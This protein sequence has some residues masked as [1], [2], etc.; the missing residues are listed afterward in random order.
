M[1]AAVAVIMLTFFFSVQVTN[2]VGNSVLDTIDED[3]V[4]FDPEISKDL[5][6]G[7]AVPVVLVLRASADTFKKYREKTNDNARQDALDDAKDEIIA[8]LDGDFAENERLDTAFLMYGILNPEGKIKVKVRDDILAV[9]KRME[10]DLEFGEKNEADQTDIDILFQGV[11]RKT[12]GTVCLLS[13]GVD[14]YEDIEK[15]IVD[16][17]CYCA[18]N[19]CDD[20]SASD[21]ESASDNHPLKLGTSQASLLVNQKTGILRNA[22]VINVKVCDGEYCD[23][24][25]IVKGLDYCNRQNADLVLVTTQDAE[26]YVQSTCP[27]IMGPVFDA[28]L[29]K[30]IPIITNIGDHY[31][32][33]GI[34]YPACSAKTITVGA[35]TKEQDIAPYANKGAADFF[36]YATFNTSTSDTSS[37]ILTSS[38]FAATYASAMFLITKDYLK[39]EGNDNHLQAVYDYLYLTTNEGILDPRSLYS[40]ENSRTIYDTRNARYGIDEIGL[41]DFKSDVNVKNVADCAVV[42]TNEVGISTLSCPQFDLPAKI[43]IQNLPYRQKVSVY[44]DLLPCP[45]SQCTNI[46]WDDDKQELTFDTTTMGIFSAVGD[47]KGDGIIS[48]CTAKGCR[49]LE[50]VHEE[51]EELQLPT[52][53][54]DDGVRAEVIVKDG[55]ELN[56]YD[57][58][59]S[60]LIRYALYFGAPLLVLIAIAGFYFFKQD[61]SEQ[62]KIIRETQN[63]MNSRRPDVK[64]DLPDWVNKENKKSKSKKK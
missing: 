24:S 35:I 37:Q 16:E 36:G 28:L 56:Q 18:N 26:E 14:I 48:M 27:V 1:V 53:L 61:D 6:A 40:Y 39:A 44:K 9:H 60:S 32:K 17:Q 23:E 29:A 19:C 34:P 25:D 55:I 58:S 8:E 22:E 30:D 59:E 62:A 52:E 50:K 33:Q 13:S 51:R 54:P 47:L 12:Q 38:H 64:L 43:T 7:T 42:Q 57:D 20:G 46:K 21:D 63:D 10:Y 31:N 41:I 4:Y 11:D 2:L 49:Q 5:D 15:Q 45:A 3:D